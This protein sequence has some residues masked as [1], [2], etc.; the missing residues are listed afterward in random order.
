[1]SELVNALDTMSASLNFQAGEKCH[2]EHKWS[3]DIREKIVQ[4]SFQ[5]V[6]TDENGIAKLKTVLSDLLKTIEKSY[7]CHEI[8]DG[9]YQEFMITL[10]KMIGHTR[11][12]VAGKGEY[13]L[14]YM[15]IITWYNF[16]PDLAMY[17]F[18]KFVMNGNDH[19]YGSWKDIKYFCQYCYKNDVSKYHPLLVFAF[20]LIISLVLILTF[21]ISTSSLSP[22]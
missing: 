15:L 3:N 2:I 12:V 11:D 14:S 21:S 5:L 9:V 10:Y 20:E 19:P 4:F 7:A 17:A 18:K 6:R 1:M 13:A 16:R 8:S 22:K